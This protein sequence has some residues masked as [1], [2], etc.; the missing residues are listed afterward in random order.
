MTVGALK[1]CGYDP[2]DPDLSAWGPPSLD[3]FRHFGYYAFTVRK[4]L[5][6]TNQVNLLKLLSLLSIV[7]FIYLFLFGF[8]I[9]GTPNPIREQM[10][11][12]NR[13]Q[14]KDGK[15]VDG[16]KSQ[17]SLTEEQERKSEKNFILYII[18]IF[19]FL[20]PYRI[21]RQVLSPNER[22]ILYAFFIMFL[23]YA[24]VVMGK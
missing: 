2:W 15:A 21:G 7:L 12:E 11:A 4:K 18:I 24:N 13:I 19:F 23:L 20:F 16:A 9:L 5:P 22:F 14:E 17:N 10:A 3:F 6:R 1:R 8:G